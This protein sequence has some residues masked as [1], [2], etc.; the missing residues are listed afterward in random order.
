MLFADDITH[1]MAAAGLALELIE[2]QHWPDYPGDGVLTFRADCLILKFSEHDDEQFLEIASVMAPG[3]F[4]W[5]G[6]IEVALGWSSPERMQS[7]AHAPPLD[8]VMNRLVQHFGDL[9]KLFFK[10]I[11]HFTYTA[12]A[13]TMRPKALHLTAVRH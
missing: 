6:D 8:E 3:R 7:R 12:I 2:A 13:R 5:F 10:N 4:F 9:K 11:D 1:R